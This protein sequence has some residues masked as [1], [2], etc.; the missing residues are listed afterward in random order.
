MIDSLGILGKVPLPI[1]ILTFLILLFI[2]FYHNN[3]KRAQPAVLLN[4]AGTYALVVLNGYRSYPYLALAQIAGPVALV[5][6]LAAALPL[7]V[8][9][10]AAPEPMRDWPALQWICFAAGP[11]VAVA[12]LSSYKKV[13]L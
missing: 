12:C 11:A 6:L 7:V 1:S 8:L 4:I 5:I 10:L 3:L 9:A 13:V 2:V